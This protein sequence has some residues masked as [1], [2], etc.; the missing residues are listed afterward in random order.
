MGEESGLFLC[1]KFES[2]PWSLNGTICQISRVSFTTPHKNDDAYS[3]PRATLDDERTS[4]LL[5]RLILEEDLEPLHVRSTLDLDNEPV[6]QPRHDRRFS[7]SDTPGISDCLRLRKSFMHV[8]LHVEI[9][10]SRS[11]RG[12]RKSMALIYFNLKRIQH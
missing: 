2:F 12:F 9:L 5:L 4:G 10:R 1:C 8:A 7:F 11:H 3:W 6:L